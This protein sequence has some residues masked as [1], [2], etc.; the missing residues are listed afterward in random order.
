MNYAHTPLNIDLMRG[1]LFCSLLWLLMDSSFWI[2]HW[3]SNL[4]P[5]GMQRE[6][7][8]LQLGTELWLFWQSAP[9]IGLLH[10]DLISGSRINPVM[11]S[12]IRVQEQ[13]PCCAGWG[14]E[15]QPQEQAW[16][17]GHMHAP[18]EEVPFWRENG[19]LQIETVSWAQERWQSLPNIC[20]LLFCYS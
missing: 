17:K 8:S 12:S 18:V 14:E 10:L 4:T 20:S 11:R 3:L 16:P 6:K 19:E 2:K 15:V 5:Q 7:L 1:F 13:R 9:S